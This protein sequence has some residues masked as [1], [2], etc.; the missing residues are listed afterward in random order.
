M[1]TCEHLKIWMIHKTRDLSYLA[2]I[3]AI[4]FFRNVYS[5]SLAVENIK[6]YV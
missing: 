2:T 5:F 1:Y 3:I 6:L 4:T